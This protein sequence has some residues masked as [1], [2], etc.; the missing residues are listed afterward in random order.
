MLRC[1]IVLIGTAFAYV[2]LL[3]WHSVVNEDYFAFCFVGL[4][5]LFIL[6]GNVVAIHA[7]SELYNYFLDLHAFVSAASRRWPETAREAESSP[8]SLDG[9]KAAGL[10]R[11][12][13]AANKSVL[14]ALVY[15]ILLRHYRLSRALVRRAR[16]ER[17]SR[18]SECLS[19][20]GG[21]GMPSNLTVTTP[22]DSIHSNASARFVAVAHHHPA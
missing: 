6:L 4:S 18:A 12:L 3:T 20:E 17:Q 11:R 7:A 19:E 2:V 15:G 1:T 5:L 9:S 8:R 14:A 21:Y 22:L 13:P 16:Q 10:N